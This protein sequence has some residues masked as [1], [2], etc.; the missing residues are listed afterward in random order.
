MFDK[1]LDILD[2]LDKMRWESYVSTF[3][4]HSDQAVNQTFIHL[5]HYASFPVILS[6]D[7]VYKIYLNF[8]ASQN[9]TDKTLQIWEASEFL[10]SPIIKELGYDI[11]EI[12]PGIRQALKDKLALKIA[13]NAKY[14]ENIRLAHFMKEYAVKCKS[15]FQSDQIEKAQ[16]L[17]YEIELDPSKAV[18]EVLKRISEAN[19]KP[20]GNFASYLL[21][22]GKSKVENGT[23]DS[24]LSRLKSTEALLKGI[25]SQSTAA[26]E[27]ALKGFDIGPET[28]G[29]KIGIPKNVKIPKAAEVSQ[30]RKLRALVIGVGKAGIFS[31]N[32]DVNS[33]ELFANK[34]EELAPSNELILKKIVG[35]ETKKENVINELNQIARD[36]NIKDDLVIY[37]SAEA[38]NTN[39]YC[40]IACFNP[41]AKAKFDPQNNY[42]KD[43]EIVEIIKNIDCA[44]I[45]IILQVDHAA[46]PYW[47][48]NINLFKSKTI[49]FASCKFEQIPTSFTHQNGEIEVCAFT[50]ALVE[51]MTFTK[52]NRNIFADSVQKLWEFF[53]D[54]TKTPVLIG[55]SE[56]YNLNFIKGI[57]EDY[58][59]KN[60]LFKANFTNK[61]AYEISDSELKN[62][63]NSY[64]KNHEQ[65]QELTN[66][67][68][69]IKKLNSELPPIF[70]LIYSDFTQKLEHLKKEKTEI[71]NLLAPLNVV[72]LLLENTDAEA[73][74][75]LM[76]SSKYRN[77]IQLIYYAG[78]DDNDGNMYLAE[79]SLGIDDFAELLNYQENVKLFFSN[80]CRSK[81]YAEYLTQMGVK[82]SYG[83]EGTVA[84]DLAAEKG[85]EFFRNLASGRPIQQLID[86]QNYNYNT[87]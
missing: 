65:A 10:F 48:E 52:I 34:I 39:N 7:L 26:I 33:A 57:D 77:R 60:Q 28:D 45:T 79:K 37:I 20:V 1:E 40:E 21:E 32:A 11:Y 31:E 15:N 18:A 86:L 14:P 85:I 49:V 81:L 83:F 35:E 82:Y 74:A 13:S 68:Q 56:T 58:D 69:E 76:K 64:L 75:N 30:K 3:C 87:R 50:N 71:L 27:D 16:I 61:S 66:K 59:L 38:R 62:L 23:D 67:L 55:N 44:S 41:N 22:Y 73:L 51:S 46:S 72:V 80:T 17:N 4:N 19:G 5:A 84:D 8:I 47:L 9:K 2:E 53:E 70:L 42:L 54:E 63:K 29:I 25:N 24:L 12:H 36:T 6:S 43:A 78:Y